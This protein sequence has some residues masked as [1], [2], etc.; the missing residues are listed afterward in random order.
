MRIFMH[1]FYKNGSVLISIKEME[2]IIFSTLDSELQNMHLLHSSQMD[3]QVLA[4]I[5][6]V[7]E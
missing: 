7:F 4:E 6:K 3:Q 1:F 2:W 5:T